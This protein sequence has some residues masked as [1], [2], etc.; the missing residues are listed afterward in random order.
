MGE[1][2]ADDSEWQAVIV[3]RSVQT[4]SYQYAAAPKGSAKTNATKIKDPNLL[5]T[6]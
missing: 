4:A 3:A 6:Y 2:L 1:G 5:G